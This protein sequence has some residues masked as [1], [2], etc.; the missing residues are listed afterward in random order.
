MQHEGQ[1][2]EGHNTKD[3]DAYEFNNTVTSIIPTQIYRLNKWVNTT[4]TTIV[5]YDKEGQMKSDSNEYIQESP[6]KEVVDSKKFGEN[7]H[8]IK[9]T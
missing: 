1:G 3:V 7:L 2:D 9:E 4:E 6:E 8:N 5:I